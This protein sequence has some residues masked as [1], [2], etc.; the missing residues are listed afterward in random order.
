MEHREHEPQ[1]GGDGRLPR[2][3][4]LH[5][6]LDREVAVVDLV[7]ERDNL[8]RELVVLLHERVERTAEGSEDERALLVDRRLELVELLLERDAHD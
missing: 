8:V 3:Q 6:L 1:V 4:V 5:P 2:E 7:V